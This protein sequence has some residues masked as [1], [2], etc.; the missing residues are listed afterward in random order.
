MGGF[1]VGY[2][3]VLCDILMAVPAGAF[4]FFG[5]EQFFGLCV[6]FMVTGLALVLSGFGMAGMQG[7]VEADGNPIRIE[8]GG[9][10]VAFTAGDGAGFFVGGG[11]RF[12]TFDAPGMIDIGGF[13]R[14]TILDPLKFEGKGFFFSERMATG[15]VFLLFLE[16]LCMQIMRKFHTGTFKP[17]LVFEHVDH[18]HVRSLGI[19]LRRPAFPAIGS[20]S[21]YG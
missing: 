17:A 10:L 11:C 18:Q 7:F 9:F 13:G 2:P 19:G 20:D 21:R 14:G 12:M 6:V 1:P 8:F 5:I 16:S 3:V 4:L 15:A